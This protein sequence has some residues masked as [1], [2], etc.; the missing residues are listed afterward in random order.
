MLRDCDQLGHA[1]TRWWLETRGTRTELQKGLGFKEALMRRRTRSMVRGTSRREFIGFCNP[2]NNPC[3][4]VWARA[5]EHNGE[6]RMMSCTGENSGGGALTGTN[7][8]APAA[9]DVPAATGASA[10]AR[11]VATKIRSDDPS[12]PI[13]ALHR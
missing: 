13:R 11:A 6:C 1:S 9:T 10:P 8:E 12:Y 4:S 5:L 3:L 7:S 2:V